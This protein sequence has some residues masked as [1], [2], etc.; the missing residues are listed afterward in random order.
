MKKK[1]LSDIHAI[2]NYNNKDIIVEH[3]Q[4]RYNNN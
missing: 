2:L 3:F 4:I 1:S